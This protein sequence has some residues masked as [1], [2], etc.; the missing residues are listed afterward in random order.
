[1]ITYGGLPVPWTVSWTGEATREL[2]QC[3]HAP[4][5]HRAV[6]QTSAQ[7]L[8]KP[9]FS[10]PHFNRQRAAMSR[11]L[12]DLCGKPLK[13]RTRVSLSQARPT[14]HA[15]TYGDI[16]Q[17]EPLLHKACAALCLKH[18]PSLKRQISDG[19]LNIR[20]VFQSAV[21]SALYSADGIQEIT[22][23]HETAFYY[24]KVQL[25]KWRD[26]DEDWLA[27]T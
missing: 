26:R 2:G 7:G 20:Q 19:V 17:V 22:G 27:A 21:Q 9:R 18:C 4:P 23:I 10:D 25:I 3:P 6:I 15:A 1:M 24:N 12:C 14:A 11:G 16:L 13:S 5:S 8:G